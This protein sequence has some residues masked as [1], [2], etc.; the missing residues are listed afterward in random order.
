[1]NEFLAVILFLILLIICASATMYLHKN[2]IINLYTTT[3]EKILTFGSFLITILIL[4]IP[5]VIAQDEKTAELYVWIGFGTASIILAIQ[6]I[7]I[8]GDIKAMIIAIIG[9]IV[10]SVIGLLLSV[11][12][13]FLVALLF[14]GSTNNYRR[15]S[16]NSTTFN[17]FGK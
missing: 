7:R 5:I 9:N 6:S 12:T 17:I 3:F 2:H 1:M 10:W 8:N 16:N 11:L 14:G 13:I 15:K 4:I